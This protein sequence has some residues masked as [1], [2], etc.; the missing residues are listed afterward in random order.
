MKAK[1][2]VTKARA[3]LIQ[4]NVF[5]GSL[6]L[7]LVMKEDSSIPTMCTNGKHIRYNPEF[8]ESLSMPEVV[9][10]LCHEVMH[11]VLQQVGKLRRGSRSAKRWGIASD[12]AVNPLLIDAGITL[13]SIALV[14]PVFKDM[15]AERIYEILPQSDDDD[16]DSDSGDGDEDDTDADPGGCGGMDDDGADGQ[17]QSKD[18]QDR[19]AADWKVAT[20]QAMQQSKAMDGGLPD[21]VKRL[22]DEILD[23]KLSWQEVLERF[24]D[25]A[26]RNDYSWNPPNRRYMQKGIY[27]PS[28]RSNEL[29]RVITA[30][31]TS[32]SIDQDQLNQY[33]G[34]LTSILGEYGA[35]CKVI[36]CD[37]DVRHVE[38]FT[39]FELP[40]DL[41]PHGGG[42]TRFTPPFKYIEEVG[43]DPACLIY[44]TDGQCDDYPEEPPYPVLWIMTSDYKQCG[45][46]DP[47][48]GEIV[49]L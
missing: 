1:Q 46:S 5:F 23:P 4:D 12:Y 40:L 11:C 41:V 6:A 22:V 16:G 21:S 31:D 42:M 32:G 20:S 26:A 27:M 47:P 19:I 18:D 2:I 25:T 43:D 14:E 38:E 9:G 45:F 10:V 8:V 15:S 39:A 33:A 17:P 28:Q 48:F 35:D 7:R 29:S 36:H 30:L 13:P 49:D 34:E 3:R 37:S 24:V 44:F